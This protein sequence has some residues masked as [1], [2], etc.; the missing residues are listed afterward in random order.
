M[1]Q[2]VATLGADGA[3]KILAAAMANANAMFCF[4]DDISPT[5]EP[6]QSYI[7]EIE[8]RRALFDEAAPESS[9]ASLVATPAAI[10]HESGIPAPSGSVKRGEFSE[11][12]K[13]RD[14]HTCVFSGMSDPAA[15][16]IFPFATSKSKKYGDLNEILTALWG[17]EKSMA[18]RRGFENA[19][20]TQSVQ[21]GISMNHQIHFWFDHARF[22]L[23]PLRETQEGIVVQWHWLKRSILKPLVHITPNHDILLQAGVTNQEW[24]DNL[25]AHRKS[26]V[27]IRTGQ[28]F[29]LQ[30]NRP[31]DMP[32]WDLLEMQWNLLRVAAICG[33]AD[34]TDDYYDDIDPEVLLAR[35]NDETVAARL[36]A[37]LAEHEDNADQDGQGQR[38]SNRT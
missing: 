7:T 29:L 19:D 21:N 32:S 4:V 27:P 3:D 13:E 25:V 8:T 37:I 35:A 31:E 10:L 15:A 33:V 18:W 1:E 36:R 17:S 14:G 20:L 28:T 11:K 12:V 30:A 16:H 2:A 9:T 34:V 38:Q 26:G 23:K 6:V 22:A 24:G 5:T